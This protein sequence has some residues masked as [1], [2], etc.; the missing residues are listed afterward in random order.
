MVQRRHDVAM[1]PAEKEVVRLMRLDLCWI[2]ANVA[3]GP[4]EVIERIMFT[5]KE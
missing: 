2:L 5:D 1:H 3:Y 4:D